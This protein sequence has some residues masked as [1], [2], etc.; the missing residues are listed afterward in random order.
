MSSLKKAR[1]IA[2]LLKQQICEKKFYLTEPVELF[3]K[4]TSLVNLQIKGSE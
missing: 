2:D 4:N 3:P 1:Q